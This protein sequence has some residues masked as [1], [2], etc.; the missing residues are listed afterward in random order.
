[1]ARVVIDANV[2]ISAADSAKL[3]R[4]L[5]PDS[6]P[7]RRAIQEAKPSWTRIEN[8]FIASS[9]L[10]AMPLVTQGDFQMSI[11]WFC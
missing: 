11:S 8:G 1:M 5:G 2:I 7:A 10:G 9:C 3:S 4:G 6:E